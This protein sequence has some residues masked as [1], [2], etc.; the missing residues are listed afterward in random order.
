MAWPSAQFLCD[1]RIVCDIILTILQLSRQVR[2]GEMA[3]VLIVDDDVSLG[4]V[5]KRLL[6]QAGL[7]VLLSC[8]VDSALRYV[9]T[10][11]LDLIVTDLKMPGK[12]GMDLLTLSRRQRPDL[13]VIMLTAYGNVESAVAAIKRGAYDFITKPFDEKELLNVITKA[14]AESRTNKE[15]ISSYFDETGPSL[16][17]IIGRTPAIER[18]LSTVVK[19]G[20]TDSTVLIT[21]ETGVGKELIAR[22]LHLTSPRRD[23]PFV[24]I[25]CAA[26]PE[27]LLES[28]LFGYEKGAFTGAVVNKPGRFEIADEGSVFLDEM[29]EIPLHLQSKLLNVL[30]DR[31]FEH[32]GGIKTIKVDVRIIAATNRDLRSAV[33]SGAFRSD[34]YY[35]LNVVPIHIPPL[36]ERKDDIPPLADHLLRRFAARHGKPVRP[37]PAEVKAAFL[38]YDWPG[39]V[40]ELENVLERMVLLSE[41]ESLSLEEVP[42]EIRGVV[43]LDS[44]STL[45]EKMDDI[46]HVTEKQMIID[47][48]N[49]TAQNRTRAAELLG[50]SRRALINK[51]KEYGL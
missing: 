13:P 22:A 6:E 27:T 19:I 12:S 4:K 3:L 39:N 41:K 23:K 32:V 38:N 21:G 43:P 35:R 44:T 33:Q 50:I 2:C 1:E 51:I 34:L 5:L 30:Q 29:G 26:I 46:L 49:R 16:P 25:N 48:L 47:A 20:P 28:E 36:R 11:D 18:V 15:L 17:E 45:R 14:L 7:K 24:K 37:I 31:S 10:Q 40:R 42:P 9:E 8:D